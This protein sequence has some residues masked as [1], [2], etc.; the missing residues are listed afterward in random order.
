MAPQIS[1]NLLFDGT[2]NSKLANF[3]YILYLN[4]NRKILVSLATF[5]QNDPYMY[6]NKSTFPKPHDLLVIVKLFISVSP[7]KSEFRVY[8]ET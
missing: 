6:T 8:R 5:N 4:V 2:K 1:V 7:L 3:I